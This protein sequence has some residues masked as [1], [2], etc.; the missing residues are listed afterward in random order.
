MK[1]S[2][3]S[4]TQLAVRIVGV[5]NDEDT[6]LLQPRGKVD[7]P[8]GFKPKNEKQ[9]HLYVHPEETVTTVAATEEG[10]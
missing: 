7:L 9:R 2:N 8:P 5:N 6:V 10:E 3:L 4:S 1:V